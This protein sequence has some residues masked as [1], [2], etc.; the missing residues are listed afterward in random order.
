MTALVLARNG[1]SVTLLDRAV[2]PRDKLCGDSV[3]PGAMR[4]LERH[5][6]GP[7]VERA[8]LRI[9]G[10]RLTGPRGAAVTGR[11]PSD[12]TGCSLLRRDL[13][14]LL[15]EAA[16]AAGARVEQGVRVAGP[17]VVG[18]NGHARVAGVRLAGTRGA[19][20]RPARVVVAAD[21]RGSVLARACGLAVHP[22]NPR[23]WAFGAY[24]EQVDG[25]SALGEMHVRVDHYL[26]VAPVPG[27]LTNACLVVQEST[28][29]RV[30]RSPE[31]ALESALA[32]DPVLRDRFRSAR[33]VS[34]ATVL[35]PLAVDASKAGVDGMLV[36]GDAAGFVDP[37]TGDG[38]R[39]ALAGGELAAAAALESLD[40]RPGAHVRLAER[41]RDA[42]GRKLR[43]NR[44]LRRLV[45]LPGGVAGAALVARGWPSAFHR[46]LD[47]AGDVPHNSP[48]SA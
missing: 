47:Y 33:R 45:D 7:A 42:F 48:E 12:R 36:A 20:H 8:G 19:S 27:G 6:L 25:M 32:D 39:I 16:I 24:F 3:N 15:L 17:M 43:V 5:G 14:R 13:D 40:G 28:A 35:G 34:R 41:R 46:L 37:M 44:L 11:Y 4:L 29:R 23:R 22:P 38:I 1:V 30:A 31:A 9:E 26:G 2:F 10:M 21:G 18:A